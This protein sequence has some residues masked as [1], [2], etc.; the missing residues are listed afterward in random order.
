[1]AKY[2][3][4]HSERVGNNSYISL[5]ER[6]DTDDLCKELKKYD[7]WFVFDGWPSFDGEV[8]T[9]GGTDSMTNDWPTEE[10]ANQDRKLFEQCVKEQQAEIR[11]LSELYR[12]RKAPLIPRKRCV[13][14]I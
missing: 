12:A 10:Q 11:R 7:A 5:R 13:H 3:I 9:T 8:Y 1:M 4:V 14:P 2:T 6:I